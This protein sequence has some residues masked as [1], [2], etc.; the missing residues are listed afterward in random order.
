[1]QIQCPQRTGA[2]ESDTDIA[3]AIHR[4]TGAH[5]WVTWGR[6]SSRTLI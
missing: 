3:P 5:P 6:L 4:D 2:K 1:L